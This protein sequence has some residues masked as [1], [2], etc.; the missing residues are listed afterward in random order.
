MILAADRRPIE[1][2][3]RAVA[4]PGGEFVGADLDRIPAAVCRL[5]VQR[6]HRAVPTV[7]MHLDFGRGGERLNVSIGDRGLGCLIAGDDR[8]GL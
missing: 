7:L 3:E 8:Q 4:S 6:I 2:F 5:G 1:F